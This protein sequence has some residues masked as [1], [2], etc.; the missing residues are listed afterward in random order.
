M[1][2]DYWRRR[3]K[4]ERDAVFGTFRKFGVRTTVPQVRAFFARAEI[5]EMGE[6]RH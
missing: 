5:Y 6:T 3:F 2:I 1:V 4:G